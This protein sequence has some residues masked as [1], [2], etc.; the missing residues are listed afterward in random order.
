MAKRKVEVFTAGCPVCEP[1]AEL[2]KN[3]A[4]DSC[5]VIVYDLNK[6]C[7]TMECREK[8]EKYGVTKLPAV[9]VNGKLLDCCQ[10][11]GV[12]EDTLRAAGVGQS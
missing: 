7:D 5:E 11:G 4:C 1:T 9:A 2:V 10:G 8:A 6:G 3:T 12:S